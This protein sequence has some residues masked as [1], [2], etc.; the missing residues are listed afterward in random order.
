MVS[1]CANP[2]CSAPFRYFHTGRLFRLETAGALERRR[3]MGHDA[4]QSKPMRRLEF[5]WLCEDC[6]RRMTLTFD[7]DTGVAVHCNARAHS[8]AA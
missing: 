4:E 3:A 7:K 5:Y 6:A 1:K 2:D 8:A